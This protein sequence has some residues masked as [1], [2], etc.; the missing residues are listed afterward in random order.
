MK[1]RLARILTWI[2][3]IALGLMIP[4]GIVMILK[5]A[6][7][8][9]V[10]LFYGDASIIESK[11]WR[12]VSRIIFGGVALPIYLAFMGWFVTALFRDRSRRPRY[13]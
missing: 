1:E 2:S 10:D 7:S 4:A 8:D 13:P 5:F 11:P 9:L 12:P 6:F 3:V